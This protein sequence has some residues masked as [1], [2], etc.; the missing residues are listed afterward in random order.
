M[1]REAEKQR[2]QNRKA[3]LAGEAQQLFR[4]VCTAGGTGRERFKPRVWF[5]H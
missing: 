2:S 3:E 4:G 1:T 5:P